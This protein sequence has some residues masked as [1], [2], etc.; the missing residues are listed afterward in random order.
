MSA[1]DVARYM[2]DVVEL[3]LGQPN[4]ALSSD[5]EWRYGSR[6]SLAVDIQAGRWFD[7]ERGEGGGVLDLIA[8]EER[9]DRAHAMQ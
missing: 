6:G 5:R 3:L 1:S 7:H 8:R 4:K 9:C 2:P